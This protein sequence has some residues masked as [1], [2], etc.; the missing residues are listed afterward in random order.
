M[1]KTHALILHVSQSCRR[2]KVYFKFC[3]PKA[4]V[5]IQNI[6][7]EMNTDNKIYS[8]EIIVKY[9]GLLYCKTRR[10]QLCF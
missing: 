6:F 3:K 5:K 7:I 10:T 8:N 1:T 9:T 4:D 2:K